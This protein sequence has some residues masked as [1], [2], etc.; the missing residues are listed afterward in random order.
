MSGF[1]PSGIYTI[2][3]V[4]NGKALDGNTTAAKQVSPQHQRIFM[5]NVVPTAKNHQWRVEHQSNGNY[6]L[7][8][9]SNNK[10]LDGNT[11]VQ[12]FN[13]QYAEPFLWDPVPTAANHQWRL[14]PT[15][16]GT[17][18]IVN[19]SNNKGLDANV[20]ATAHFDATYQSPF[21]WEFTPH[22][23]NH[24]WRFTPVGQIYYT[25]TCASHGK[26][27]DANTGAV[28]NQIS[29][30]HPRPYFWTETPTAPNHQWSFV[31]V[32]DGFMIVSRSSGLALDGNP[33]V[34]Q[35]NPSYPMPFMYT[36]TPSAANHVWKLVPIGGTD[37]VG[38]VNS[39]NGLALDGNV[40]ACLH[41][42]P[43]NPSPFLWKFTPSAP[44]H[45]WRLH[46]CH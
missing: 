21:L 31:P 44:N 39:S 20:G 8:N 6:L 30:Q 27:L 32:N 26:A 14:V 42:A 4:S 13:Q 29:P 12:Q 41:Q 35:L 37:C 23:P 34:P 3:S 9:M 15:G 38:I 22:A 5:W 10:A 11:G 2:T 43:N 28:P 25:I 16:P 1:L 19:S 36:P 45:Q 33:Q 7:I 18:G 46:L 40:G 17:F 24:Q